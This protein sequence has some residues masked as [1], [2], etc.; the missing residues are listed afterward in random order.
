MLSVL[1]D[2]RLVLSA[3]SPYLVEREPKGFLLEDE[4]PFAVLTGFS[5]AARESERVSG[6]NYAVIE[7]SRGRIDVMLSDGTGSGEKAEAA[8]EKVLEL[9]EKMLEAGCSEGD[10]ISMV[11]GA[12]AAEGG[13]DN[14][15]T[16]D[17][18][19]VDLYGG[20]CE[21]RKAGGAATFLKRAKQVE[22][23]QSPCLPL[24]IFG[25]QETEPIC[26]ELKDGDY[27]VMVTDGVLDAFGEEDYGR[28][29]DFL[30][31]MTEQ[32]PGE[33]AEKVLRGALCA[34]GGRIRDDMTVGVIGLWEN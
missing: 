23:L 22:V 28:M 32:N 19:S 9:M 26:E 17:L 34:S 2:K 16:L 7:R 20:T 13:D 12:L 27:L 33:I 29:R 11:N 3:A 5:G 31:G 15:P 4:P 8:S 30:S 24:G 6:D 1:L 18:C 25:Q 21:I 14:H 10:A